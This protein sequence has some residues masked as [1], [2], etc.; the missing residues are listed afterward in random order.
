MIQDRFRKQTLAWFAALH[1]LLYKIIESSG[2]PPQT[3]QSTKSVC[4]G[5]SWRNGSCVNTIFLRLNT[6]TNI[7]RI[8]LHSRMQRQFRWCCQWSS[9]ISSSLTLNMSIS[10]QRVSSPDAKWGPNGH[11]QS[12]ESPLALHKRPSI[13]E[14]PCG[15]SGNRQN[16]SRS[17][18]HPCN[19]KPS[20]KSIKAETQI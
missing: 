8:Q 18:K 12:R 10:A 6:L 9:S 11:I 15:N 16:E 13:D 17:S 1:F 4:S 5:L 19:L 20:L 14:A 7:P 2:V 3:L